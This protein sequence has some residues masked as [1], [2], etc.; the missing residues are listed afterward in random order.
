MSILARIQT[1]FDDDIPKV[2][3]PSA[4]FY[5]DAMRIY[6]AL[7]SGTI[8]F[9]DAIQAVELLK[10]NPE[11]ARSPIDPTQM[12]INQYYTNKMLDNLKTL[13]K[14]NLVTRDSI[15]S[16]YSFVFI[17]QDVTISE[18]DFQV[19]GRMI[20]SPRESMTNLASNLDIAP[21][22]VARS[23]DRLKERH[24]L[25]DRA[26]LDNTPW[27]INTLIAFFTPREEVDWQSIEDALLTY[28]YLKTI[29]KTTV[30]DLGYL[31][32]IVP[33]YKKNFH[34]LQ[35]SLLN[36]SKSLFNYLSVH[37]QTSMGADRNLSL[38]KNGQ[39]KF[40]ESVRLVFEDKTLPNP[41]TNPRILKC[42]EKSFG[43]GKMDYRI[44]LACKQSAR[45]T[46]SELTAALLRQRVEV[47]SKRITATTRKLYEKSLI[48]PYIVFSLG[49]SSDFCFEVIC[50]EFW[51]KRIE[52][53]LPLLPYTISSFS[54][55]GVIIWASVPGNQQV[56]FYQ[57]FRSLEEHSGV[58]SVRSIMTITMKGSRLISDLSDTWNF[59]KDGYTVPEEEFDLEVFLEDYL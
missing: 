50:N 6:L 38:Y 8:N 26:F 47:D 41:Q 2:E 48:L 33:G 43:F 44:A 54:S 19:L 39:W 31:S 9:D 52:S 35:R 18:I 17:P 12:P 42:V 25:R 57:L 55:R 15:R 29:L 16:A 20:D 7:S 30:S 13:K 32:F 5:L 24:M 51:Q 37:T 27:G 40:P 58:E 1:P 23:I 10:K 4:R 3:E 45:A 21:R 49:L 22:T 28:P 34:I 14:F 36:L 53:V 56:E 59:T 11:S 46:P